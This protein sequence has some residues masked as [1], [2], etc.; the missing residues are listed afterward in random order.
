MPRYYAPY[1]GYA[2]HPMY[3]SGTSVK[4]VVIIALIVLALIIGIFIYARIAAKKSLAEETPKQ[5]S[6]E[7]F[8]AEE[9][10]KIRAMAIGIQTDLKGLSFSHDID[11]YEQLVLLTDRMFE[12]VCIDYK[13]QAGESMRSALVGDKTS[14]VMAQPFNSNLYERI[15]NRMNLLSVA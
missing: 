14:F 13:R 10:K 6:D 4:T 15:L 5:Y 12:A 8:T 9:S 1:G 3:D 7:K 11:L 2:P